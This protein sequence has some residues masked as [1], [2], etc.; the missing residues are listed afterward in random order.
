MGV[1]MKNIIVNFNLIIVFCEW[2]GLSLN[3]S[4]TEACICPLWKAILKRCIFVELIADCS[5]E[6]TEPK[7]FF[8]L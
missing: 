3:P 1:Q 4:Q 6:K 8:I 5:C 2:I 7:N